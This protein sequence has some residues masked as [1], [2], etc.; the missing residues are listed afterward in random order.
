MPAVAH[1]IDIAGKV[2]QK[3]LDYPIPRLEELIRGVTERELRLIIRLGY[4]LG[5]FIGFISALINVLLS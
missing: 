2:E 1:R 3:I 5:A 4:L